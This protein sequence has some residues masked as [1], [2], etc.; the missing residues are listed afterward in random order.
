MR[1]DTG[2]PPTKGGPTD[3]RRRKKRKYIIILKQTKRERENTLNES[4][5]STKGD[6]MLSVVTFRGE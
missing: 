6:K 1:P 5:L 2:D 4:T 3:I